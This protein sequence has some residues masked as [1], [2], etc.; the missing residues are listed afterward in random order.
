VVDEA[1]GTTDVLVVL[2]IESISGR[3]VNHYG[4]DAQRFA[5]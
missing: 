5:C 4:A 3:Y 1:F 2:P